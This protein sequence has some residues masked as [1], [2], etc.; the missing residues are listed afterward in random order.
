M[1]KK[2]ESFVAHDGKVFLSEDA[3]VRHEAVEK[4]CEIIPEFAM[5]RTRLEAS[6]D[7]VA[8]AMG[9]IVDYRRR[10]PSKGPIVDP[11][12]CTC[13]RY[14]THCANDCPLHGLEG[15][16]ITEIVDLADRLSGVA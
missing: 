12:A 6:L 15:E 11:S 13:Q 4:L 3:A 2:V 1:V 5:V 14:P 7:A 9:P 8:E 16:P 10:V